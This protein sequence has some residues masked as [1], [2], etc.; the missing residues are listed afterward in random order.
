MEENKQNEQTNI[1]KQPTEN[2]INESVNTQ[3]TENILIEKQV[4]NKP[5]KKI[6]GF[7]MEDG[8]VQYFSLE[9]VLGNG[10]ISESGSVKFKNEKIWFIKNYRGNYC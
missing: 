3:P 9:D 4:K 10:K 5:N 1:N 6:V 7:I 2:T 8:T